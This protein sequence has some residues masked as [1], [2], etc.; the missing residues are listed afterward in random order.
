MEKKG[1]TEMNVKEKLDEISKKLDK[2]IE[3]L[4]SFRVGTCT[5]D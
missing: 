5:K 2:I 1:E 4:R 3:L